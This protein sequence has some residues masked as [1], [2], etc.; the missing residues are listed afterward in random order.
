MAL[1]QYVI[2]PLLLAVVHASELASDMSDQG[3]K[4]TDNNI[5]KTSDHPH[6]SSEMNRNLLSRPQLPPILS[7]AKPPTTPAIKPTVKPT[8]K[9]SKRPSRTPSVGP[10]A[11]PIARP[12]ETLMAHPTARPTTRPSLR[13]SQ[14]PVISVIQPQSTRRGS[15]AIGIGL[16][17]VLGLLTLW[18]AYRLRFRCLSTAVT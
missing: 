18:L 16:G 10:T 3:H 6:S 4:T 7:P 12:T 2:L 13:N 14:K 9:P 8:A 1:C 5:Q 15:V 11:K 17:S